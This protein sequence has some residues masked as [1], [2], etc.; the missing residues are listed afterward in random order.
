MNQEYQEYMEAYEQGYREVTENMEGMIKN[1]AHKNP[2]YSKGM[3]CGTVWTLAMIAE[4]LYGQGSDVVTMA[5]KGMRF[6]SKVII[7]VN[8]EEDEK[9]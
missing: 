9:K 6:G 5:A 2:G 1:F 4:S 8:D 3:I 7:T